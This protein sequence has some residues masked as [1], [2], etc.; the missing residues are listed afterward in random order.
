VNEHDRQ[1][2]QSRGNQDHRQRQPGRRREGDD[3]EYD[4]VPDRREAAEPPVVGLHAGVGEIERARQRHR[5]AR[6]H[7][8]GCRHH[9][10]PQQHRRRH[11][12]VGDEIDDEVE[13]R[14]VITLRPFLD[15]EAS[16]QRPVN[17]I[18]H[19]R[20]AEPDESPGQVAGEHGL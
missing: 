8:I 13:Q 20:H 3:V 6:D 12:D 17:R 5:K 14:P 16:R 1:E 11:E 7:P 18:H 4:D 19:Q 15:R 10:R 9:L 2:H